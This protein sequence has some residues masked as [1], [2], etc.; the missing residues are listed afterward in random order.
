MTKWVEF[1]M[2]D[3]QALERDTLAAIDAA[4][5]ERALDDVR[6]A[7]LGKKG[8]ISELLKTLGTMSPDERRE[9]GARFNALRDKIAGAIEARKTALQSAALDARLASEKIDVTL[10][11]RPR[12]AAPYIP[13]AR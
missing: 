10:P 9:A 6:V 4:A 7:A 12:R 2:A 11:P 1:A 13:S 3:L 5:D 8:A